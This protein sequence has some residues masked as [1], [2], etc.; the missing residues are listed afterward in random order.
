MTMQ[1]I[2]SQ[3]VRNAIQNVCSDAGVLIEGTNANTIKITNPISFSIAGQLYAKAATDNIA[4]TALTAQAADTKCMY[5]VCIDAA[6]AVSLVKGVEVTTA[7][8]DSAYLPEQP[9]AVCVIGAFKIVTVAVTFE[10][11]TDDLAKSGVTDTFYDLSSWNDTA[12]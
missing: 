8:G 6:G 4:M 12:Y 9:A 3:P 7:S 1:A 10:S 5:L 11:G 2:T